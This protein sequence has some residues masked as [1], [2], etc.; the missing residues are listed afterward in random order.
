MNE[1]MT[2]NGYWIAGHGHSCKRFKHN[3]V[4]VIMNPRGY[5][6][7]NPE[8]KPDLIIEV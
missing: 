7:E 6:K 3:N 5:G 2:Y 1:Y 4:E 8:F